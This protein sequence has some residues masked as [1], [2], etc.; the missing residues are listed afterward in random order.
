MLTPSKAKFAAEYIATGNATQSA[1]TAGYSVKTAKSQGSR[2]LTDVDVKQALEAAGATA[3]QRIAAATG[4][5]STA[6][7]TAIVTKDLVLG[8]LLAL[9]RDK[10]NVPPSV[11]RQAWR[12]LGEHLSL[13]KTVVDHQLVSGLAEQLGLDPLAVEAEAEAILRGSR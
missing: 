11:R 12:D 3:T 8:G 9:A 1:I 6:A 2:L 5:A 7:V 4:K 10:K 13:F